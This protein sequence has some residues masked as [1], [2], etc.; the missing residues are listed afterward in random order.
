MPGLSGYRSRVNELSALEDAQRMYGNK[1][2]IDELSGRLEESGITDKFLRMYAE[3]C[4]YQWNLDR[5][6]ENLENYLVELR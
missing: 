2:W 1:S 6:Q 4:Q 3:A 5:F